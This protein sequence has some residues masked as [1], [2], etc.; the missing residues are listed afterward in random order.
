MQIL[1]QECI[2]KHSI[3]GVISFEADE[4]GLISALITTE[5]CS[6][7]LYLQGAHLTEWCPSGHE[8]VL[9]LSERS[10]IAPGQA[11]RGGIP[12]IFPWFGPRRTNDYSARSDGP[13]H[14]FART[15]NWQI[16]DA[17]VKN[18]TDVKLTLS[19]DPDDTARSLGCEGF[20]LTYELVIGENLALQL[21]VENRSKKTISFEEA[22]HSYF[23][24]GDAQ[25][26]HI[27]GLENT[28][29]FDKTDDFKLKH[30]TEAALTLS[31]E[32]DRPYIG[33]ETDVKIIDPVL[34]RQIIVSKGNSRTTVI[35]NPWADSN[36][37]DMSTDG[38]LR[39]V[40]VE[41]AN[42]LDD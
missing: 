14:G 37:A 24:V 8:P 20:R 41:S 11:I 19:L 1:L 42:A 23:T 13:S 38:W 12:V 3:P 40:C 10:M 32:T 27:L 2:D 28:D 7:T 30:Q 22:F 31:G 26:I 18:G 21:T 35:W 16:S 36:L 34:N 4:Q 25:Q 9:F 39:M 15:C 17:K 29:Y 6:A 5:A 33:T